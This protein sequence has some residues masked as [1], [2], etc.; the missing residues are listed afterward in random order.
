[1]IQ[2]S[3][4]RLQHLCATIPD[5]LRKIP[6]A[7]FSKK[8]A[9]EKWSKQEI[10]GHLIDSATNN[11]QRFIRI[12]FE[13]EPLIM[14]AQNEWNESSHYN[15]MKKE[16]VIHFWQTYNLHLAE[17]IKRIDPEKLHRKG[18]ANDKINTLAWFITD[19]VEHMEYHLR[20]IVVYK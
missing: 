13:H 16:H 12:Q 9:P 17:V 10:L 4:D 15:N 3:I 7:D 20:Q 5:L 6:D 8:P 2:H 11:H 18:I 1:M 14:Y 19:Y